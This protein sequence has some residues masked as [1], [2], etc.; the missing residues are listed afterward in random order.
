MQSRCQSAPTR[1]TKYTGTGSKLA[2][3]VTGTRGL[4]DGTMDE[5]LG[6]MH[7]TK[8]TCHLTGV[9]SEW[10]LGRAVTDEIEISIKSQRGVKMTWAMIM[11]T[12]SGTSDKEWTL[13]S[14]VPRLSEPQS[15]L[16]SS[17]KRALGAAF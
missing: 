12:N 16:Q 9:S 11:I 17:S 15:G 5:W 14:E 4:Y 3:A 7:E 8:L 10:M 1:R 13:R 2:S 6:L